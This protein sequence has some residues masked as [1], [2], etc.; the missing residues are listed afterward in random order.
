MKGWFVALL[1]GIVLLVFGVLIAV[2]WGIATHESII[3]L[4]ESVDKRFTALTEAYRHRADLAGASIGGFRSCAKLEKEPLQQL[5]TAQSNVMSI[6]LDMNTLVKP[7][8][9]SMY[10]ERQNELGYALRRVSIAVEKFTD[11]RKGE[12]YQAIKNDLREADREVVKAIANYNAVATEYNNK[13]TRVPSN[14]IAGFMGR[15]AKP[16]FVATPDAKRPVTVRFD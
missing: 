13:V 2:V 15:F 11:F 10:Q 5:V 8:S 9:L 7:A 12:V 4:E 6:S 1:T 3:T 16:V 14:I